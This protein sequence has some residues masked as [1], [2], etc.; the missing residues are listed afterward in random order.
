MV[1]SARILVV[2]DNEQ[3]RALAQAAL[4]D[5]GYQVLCESSGEAGI[6][7]FARERPDCILLDV[8]MPGTDGL[9]A[10]ARIRALPGG[11]ETPIVFL[12]ALRDIDTFERALA[13][14]ADDFL[15]KPVR[16]AE[17]I[18]RVQALLEARRMSAELRQHYELI[19][20]QR[21]DLMRLQLQ[22]ERL[23][24]LIVHDLKNPVHSM[25][26]YAQLLLREP[27]LPASARDSAQHIR[28]GARSLTRL[29]MNLLDVSKSE[30]GKLVAH[31]DAVELGALAGEVRA[32]LDLRARTAEVAI[33][34]QGPWPVA[35]AD[36]E[37][38]RRV[39]EN[40]TENAIKYAPGGS[41][42]Q[43]S[44]VQHDGTVELRVADRGRGVPN[45]LREAIFQPFVQN[46]ADRLVAR[47]GRGLGLTF[48]R[49]A[50][51]A[52]GGRIWVEDG[53]P[54]AVFCLS[55]PNA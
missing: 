46:E 35:H 25:D 5:E 43:L 11:P 31:A 47:S 17:L 53:A 14:G 6:A 24:A 18:A 32:A 16:P 23:T 55:L 40:L 10:C 42:V 1:S 20:N 51:E 44:A 29:I 37:L 38:L 4:E 15:T 33:E 28:E 22:K 26:L 36:A 34:C 21:D 30:E 50:V 27:G 39:L 52:H 8:R 49:L 9:Q 45:E 19:R 2:D 54:G 3:N 7:A 41:A 12:T 13:A 48:C